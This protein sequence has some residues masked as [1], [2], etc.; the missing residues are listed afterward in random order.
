MKLTYRD[1][2]LDDLVWVRI[3]YEKIFPEGGYN[4]SKR[5]EE[6]KRLLLQQPLIDRSH[7]VAGLRIRRISKTPFSLI[8]R[9]AGE[10]IEVIRVRDSRSNPD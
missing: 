6:T 2:A 1:S 8:Y 10:E 7:D 5:F 4:A 3:Y 9:V